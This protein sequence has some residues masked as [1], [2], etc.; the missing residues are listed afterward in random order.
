MSR[1]EGGGGG[2]GGVWALINRKGAGSHA[3]LFLIEEGWVATGS[4]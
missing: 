4:I 3:F 2:G 1:G